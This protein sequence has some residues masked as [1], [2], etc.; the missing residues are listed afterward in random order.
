M[1]LMDFG[2]IIFADKDKQISWMQPKSLLASFKQCTACNVQMAFSTS[3]D[4]S[5]GYRFV[6]IT[7]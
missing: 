5:D 6:T 7:I 4:I 1:S 3:S 2:P